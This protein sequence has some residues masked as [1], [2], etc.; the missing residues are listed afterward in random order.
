MYEFDV[1]PDNREAHIFL[2][3]EHRYIGRVWIVDETVHV[4]PAEA[5][6]WLPV[7]DAVVEI[8]KAEA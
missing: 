6:M 2:V 4:E 8:R 7:A 1:Y 3:Y 5:V